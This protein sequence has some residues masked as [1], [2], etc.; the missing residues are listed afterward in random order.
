MGLQLRNDDRT[1]LI[2]YDLAQRI[3]IR[4]TRE[5]ALHFSFDK[6]AKRLALRLENPQLSNLAGH[7]PFKLFTQKVPHLTFHET[8]YPIS[9]LVIL[10]NLEI[11]FHMSLR[12]AVIEISF[13]IERQA[14]SP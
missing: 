10:F 2:R 11:Y 13:G 3:G 6:F 1:N 7:D 14:R 5:K 8:L 9:E 4:V 12:V